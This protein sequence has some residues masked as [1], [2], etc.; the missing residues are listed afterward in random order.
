M[1]CFDINQC[2][3]VFSIWTV[4]AQVRRADPGAF[5]VAPMLIIEGAFEHENLLT[6]PMLMRIEYRVGRPAHERDM[7]ALKLVQGHHLKAVD[8]SLP[9]A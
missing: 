5:W 7:L 2:A 6:T 9:P 1:S 8:Q 4:L 3:I